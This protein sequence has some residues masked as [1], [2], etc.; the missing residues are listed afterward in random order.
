MNDFDAMRCDAMRCDAMRYD[1][2]R[3]GAVRCGAVRWP[4]K[5]CACNVN[6]EITE[7]AAF[8]N[9]TANPEHSGE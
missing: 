9:T 5:Q 2:M 1:A 7:T 3:C 6:F 4:T 8:T